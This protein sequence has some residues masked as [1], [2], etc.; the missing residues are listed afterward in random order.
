MFHPHD[1]LPFPARPN[2]DQYK[3]LAKDL[4]KASRSDDSAAIGNWAANW[5]ASLSRNS[6]TVILSGVTAQRS[7]AD[8]QSKVCPEPAEGDPLSPG[9]STSAKRSSLDSF[10]PHHTTHLEQFAREKLSETPTLAAAQFVIA[11]AHGFE[12]WPK[13]ANHLEASARTN[14]AVNH[15]EQAADAIVTGDAAT[16]S[17]LLK[18]HPDLPRAHSTRRHNA[19]ILH[20]TAAN[21]VEDYRQ[22][23]PPNIVPIAKLLLDAGADVNAIADLYGGSTTLSL[24]ATSIHPERA[25]VQNQLLQLLLDHGATLNENSPS[26]GIVNACLANGR[27][28]AAEFLAS[29]GA[30]LDLE[31]AAGVGRLDII[32]TFFNESTPASAATT[33]KRDRGFLWAC[34]YGRNEVVDFLLN[35]GVPIQTQANTGQTALHWA[36][37]GGHADTIT[38]L[39]SRGSQFEARNMYGGTALGQAQWSAAHAD[40]TID[41]TEIIDLL[42]RHGAT[43]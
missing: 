37:I 12:S 42:K 31:A 35:Q 26:G 7:G 39:L 6:H 34:E 28:R 29:R 30:I 8:A 10:S 43:E 2:L 20:Y 15:F 38:L 9:R 13:F 22:K 23:T 33:L 17:H 1:A 4:L 36:V 3:K 32:K 11:R 24:T 40:S 27:T 25:G 41:Y 16:L 21:G 5:I 19:T 18:K 14:S